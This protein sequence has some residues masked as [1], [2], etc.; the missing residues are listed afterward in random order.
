MTKTMHTIFLKEK[1]AVFI[2]LYLALAFFFIAHLVDNS[3]APAGK[4]FNFIC[5]Q[6]LLSTLLTKN[7]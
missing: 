5:F 1:L 7:V 2:A 3:I 6:S 4:S